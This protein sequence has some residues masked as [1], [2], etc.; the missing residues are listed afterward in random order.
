[1]KM[2]RLTR[3]DNTNISLINCVLRL[4]GGGGFGFIG[5]VARSCENN[6]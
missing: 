3:E 5:T 1:M 4:G 6:A 2:T